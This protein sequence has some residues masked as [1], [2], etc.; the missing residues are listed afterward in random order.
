MSELEQA[1]VEEAPKKKLSA[2]LRGITQLLLAG[3]YPGSHSQLI[4]ESVGILEVLASVEE[5][6]ELEAEAKV[7]V[8]AEEPKLEVVPDLVEEEKV[9]GQD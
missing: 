9:D 3:L 2:V 1:Q 4:F 5:K 7:E 8:P 6:K